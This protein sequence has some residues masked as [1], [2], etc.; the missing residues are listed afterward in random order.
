MIYKGIGNY[1]VWVINVISFGNLKI[2]IW[3]D[4]NN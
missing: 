2:V 3:L 4:K 1:N